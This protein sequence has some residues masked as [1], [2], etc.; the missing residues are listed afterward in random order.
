MNR[1]I[2]AE[3]NE[4]NENR[5]IKKLDE[6]KRSC[7]IYKIV[8]TYSTYKEALQHIS[9][10]GFKKHESKE[11]ISGRKTFFRWGKIKQRSKKQCDAKRMIFENK[12]K[13]DFEV[14]ESNTDHTCDE[15]DEKQQ[16][17][18]ISEKMKE[19]IISCSEKRMTPKYI[20][21]HIDEMREHHGLFID[22]K[23]P[24]MRQI[25]YIVS[26]HKATKTPKIIELGQIIEWAETNTT[27]PEEIDSPFV[28]G[29]NHSDED[30]E[31]KFQI[32][33]ST[34]RMIDH[35][36]AQIFFCVDATYKLNYQGYPFIVV[37]AIDKCRKFHPLCFA[38]CTH[39]STFDYTFV[40]KSLQRFYH[41]RIC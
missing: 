18:T 8:R 9:T 1:T 14:H 4:T 36:A 5:D 21:A 31:L 39:E 30:E 37:G 19:I 24:A 35:C 16:V 13:I 11:T 15:I 28:I 26:T 29:F 23:T 3:K 32:V 10:E 34:C 6:P 27:V 7:I 25:Y 40:F 33:V 41:G 22:E 17:K 2:Q 38:L 20:V 12:S